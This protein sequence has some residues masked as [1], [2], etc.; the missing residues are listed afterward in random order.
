MTRAAARTLRCPPPLPVSQPESRAIH[1]AARIA[2]LYELSSANAKT[3]R[4]ARAR[5]C[6]QSLEAA[7]EACRAMT[8]EYAKTFYFATA[9]QPRDKARSIFAIYAWCRTLDE[10]V[11]GAAAASGDAPLPRPS[12]A[13]CTATPRSQRSVKAYLTSP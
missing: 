1:F 5:C 6:V 8:A 3:E 10:R 7:Y 4:A 12:D 9:F 2:P 11:D 13:A